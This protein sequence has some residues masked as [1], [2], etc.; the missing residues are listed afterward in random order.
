MFFESASEER[1]HAIKIIGY[2]LMRG[3]LTKDISQLIRDPVRSDND[4]VRF[5]TLTNSFVTVIVATYIGNMVRRLERVERC[6]EIRSPC[7][8]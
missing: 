6:I 4:I 8:S 7:H 3:S 2:L 5:C 1:E